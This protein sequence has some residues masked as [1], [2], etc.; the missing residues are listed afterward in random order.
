MGE[1]RVPLADVVVTEDD[2]AA[3]ADVYRSGWLSMG[4][5]TEALEREF[6]A[7]VGAR[8]AFAVANG[9]AALHLVCAAAGLG[10]GDD[11]IVP[12]LTFVATVNAIAYTGAKPVFADVVGVTEPWLDPGAAE[13]AATER[14]RAIMT[15][16]YG[17]HPGCTADLAALARR[18]GLILLEDAAHAVGS[19]LGDRHLGTFGLAGAFSFFSNKNLAVGEGGMVVTDDDEIAARMRLLRSHGMTTLTWDRHRGH[20]SGYDVVDLGFNYRIDEPRAALA[21]RRLARLDADN[22]RRAELDARYRESL[23]GADG[24]TAALPQLSGA[25]LAHHLFTI[26][27]DDGVDRERFREAVASRGVQTSVHYPPA[28][29]FSIYAADVD[30]PV[31][32]AYAARAVTL[33]MF[34]TMTFAQQ[35]EVVGAVRAA[36]AGRA[37]ATA[38]RGRGA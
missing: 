20:A 35:D 15:M 37:A 18:R 21:R 30:L 19:R 23:A 16:T 36:L 10:P 12:S 1:W 5:Q 13:G 6:A 33:P 27:L 4:P 34:A 25:V 22:A 3:V 2:I 9:T 14:T 7:Y 28:H 29:R 26:V 38:S 24:L 17:G 8:H 31:T 11:A 32:D